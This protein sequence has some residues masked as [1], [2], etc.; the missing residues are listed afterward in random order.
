MMENL[1]A[2][3]FFHGQPWFV[4]WKRRQLNFFM[5][6][7]VERKKSRPASRSLTQAW[8]SISI[9]KILKHEHGLTIFFIMTHKQWSRSFYFACKQK[10]HRKFYKQH[11]IPFLIFMCTSKAAKVLYI[12]NI[13]SCI[14]FMFDFRWSTR[15]FLH[16]H[17]T[18][19][20]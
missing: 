6:W 18:V 7:M 14:Y 17:W 15:L 12:H 5:N 9:V 1:V 8:D 2:G 11:K 4:V 10:K 16:S 19:G 3:K 20:T 13:K